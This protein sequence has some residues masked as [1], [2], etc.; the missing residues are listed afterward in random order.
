M[1]VP[2]SRII[3]GA[4]WVCMKYPGSGMVLSEVMITQEKG[5]WYQSSLKFSFIFERFRVW[6]GNIVKKSTDKD[7]NVPCHSNDESCGDTSVM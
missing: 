1:Q 7:L 3:P 4:V 2:E 5:R 6:A